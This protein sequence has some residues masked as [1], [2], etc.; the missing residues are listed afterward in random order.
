MIEIDVQVDIRAATRWLDDVQ[1]KQIPFALS[2]AINDTAKEV[3]EGLSKEMSV[4][5]RPKPATVKGTFVKRSNKTNLEA[6]IGLKT[7]DQG[8]PTSEYLHAQINPGTRADKRSEILLQRAGILPAGYQ[9]RPGSGARLD[10]Y[11]N[12]SRGQIVQILSYFQAFGG[13]SESGRFKGRTT[14]SRAINR[15]G[16]ATGKYF[17]VPDGY[18]GLA[19]G[20]WRRQGHKIEPVLI[21]IKPAIYRKRYD[22][23]GVANKIVRTSFVRQFDKAFQYAM[24]TAK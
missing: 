13:I 12:M 4:F 9:T 19:T 18:A 5:D 14:K 7:R 20:V 6:I 17:I 11:G 22:F 23:Y 3:Q 8:T 2:K 16:A 15:T 24:S 10:A 1:R 21:F